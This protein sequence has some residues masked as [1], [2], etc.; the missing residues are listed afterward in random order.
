MLFTE[1]V[2]ILKPIIGYSYNTSVF[3]KKLFEPI[4]TKDKV[5]QSKYISQNTFNVYYN[6]QTIIIKISRKLVSHIK[7]EQF[8]S[9]LKNFP[10]EIVHRIYSVFKSSIEDIVLYNTS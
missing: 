2:Y 10:E 7:S 9:Y 5:Y 4:I 1:F 6:N 8:R 3:I